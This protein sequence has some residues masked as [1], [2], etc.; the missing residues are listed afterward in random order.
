MLKKRVEARFLGGPWNNVTVIL[1]ENRGRDV[2]A[3]MVGAA[4]YI[5]DYDYVCFVH[6]KK[7][8]QLDTG[9]KGY[10]FSER[11]FQNLLGT[12]ELVINILALFESEPY[13]GMLCPPPPNHAEYYPLLG[14]EWGLNF[15]ATQRLANE[16]KLS[17]PISSDHEPVAPLGTMFWFR[18]KAL[19]QLLE[20]GWKYTDFP[21]EPIHTDGTLLHAM[22]RIY[23][24]VVQNSG[25]YCGWVLNDDYAR[26]EWNNLSF[27]LRSMN[28]HAMRVYG[29]GKHSDLIFTMECWHDQ[30]NGA[31]VCVPSS[32]LRRMIKQKLRARIPQP[33]WEIIKKMYH[34]VGGKKWLD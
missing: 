34:L 14:D 13:L 24:F 23:P 11:C 9:I 25:Y 32:T 5:R 33:V 26:T 19:R 16:L 10:S 6:D 18:P 4:Q 30:N 21:E 8:S 2:S 31:A 1:I 15:A 17:C 29:G 12:K 22:E 7:V 20:H 3:L 28:I 27:M